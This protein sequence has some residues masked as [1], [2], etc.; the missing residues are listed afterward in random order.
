LI[1]RGRCFQTDIHMNAQMA[2]AQVQINE[3]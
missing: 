3:L 1:E 2:R